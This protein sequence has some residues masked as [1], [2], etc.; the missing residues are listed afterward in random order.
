LKNRA[1]NKLTAEE[2]NLGEAFSKRTYFGQPSEV[3]VS[4]RRLFESH[5]KPLDLTC[6]NPTRVGLSLPDLA[7]LLSST[8]PSYEP[9]PKGQAAAREAL[10]KSYQKRA[11]VTS[12]QFILTASTSEAYSFTLLTLCD[13]GDSILVPA[14]SYPLFDQLAQLCGVRLI[15]Y[16][17]DY[18]GAFHVNLGRLPD[19]AFVKRQKVKALFCVSPNN[20]T[21]N[22]VTAEELERFV[23]LGVPLV[24]DE[25][26][27]PYDRR[28]A[29]ADPLRVTDRCA[30]VILLDGVS[31]RAGAPG[32]KVGW[33]LAA[34]PQ[35]EGFLKRVDW[36]SD[37]FLSC[38]SVAQHVLPGLLAS[39]E[40]VQALIRARI[41]ESVKLLHSSKL[42]ERGW[43]LLSVDGGF[44]ALLRVPGTFD[45]RTWWRKLSGSGIWVE[46]GELYGFDQSPLFALSLLT[47]PEVLREALGR[48]THLD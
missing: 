43:T 27:L 39:E 33:L 21:G 8:P 23:S 11:P 41:D 37:A 14:P 17:L 12:E 19:A 38:S 16:P 7:P 31:K 13:P 44:T 29:G 47:P 25:V 20:P 9:D 32:L 2:D 45:E 3:H 40:R 28:R 18:D 1:E 5:G 34:G 26:F 35:A 42:D 10:A 4:M 22:R 48:F 15:H 46:P 30:L 24:F 36:V 6:S